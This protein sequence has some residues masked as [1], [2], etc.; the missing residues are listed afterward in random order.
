MGL[1]DMF[2][3]KAPRT[4]LVWHEPEGCFATVRISKNRLQVGYMYREK[5][6]S[7][8]PDSGWRFFEGTEDQA[9]IDDPSNT[10]ILSIHTVCSIDPAVIPY[11]HAP[12]GTAWE[13]QPDGTFIEVP[14]EIPEDEDN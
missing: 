11:L 5:T 8:F 1:F 2:R 4:H 3:K 7:R 14:F 13:R 10:Q 6:E 9:F 12:Y